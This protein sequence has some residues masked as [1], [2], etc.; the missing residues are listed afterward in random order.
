MTPLLWML[1]TLL[2]LYTQVACT[3]AY[4][5]TLP[6]LAFISVVPAEAKFWQGLRKIH[7]GIRKDEWQEHKSSQTPK[8][9]EKQVK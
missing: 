8:K 7:Q 1:L 6:I 2:S 5:S 3:N 9:N 4:Y